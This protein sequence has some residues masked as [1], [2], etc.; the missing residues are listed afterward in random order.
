MSY[1]AI[2]THVQPGA[3]AAPRLACARKLAQRFGAH[4]IGV[5]AE[6]IQTLTFDNGYYALD[7]E[8]TVAMRQTIEQ[9]LDVAHEDFKRETASLGAAG[10]SWSRGIDSP[11]PALAA[12]SRA[13]DIIVAGGAPRGA[14]NAYP[15]ISAA[16]LTIQAGRPVLVAPPTAKDLSAEKVVLA[17]KDTREARRAL[18]D[19]LPFLV[20]ARGVLVLEVTDQDDEE[21]ARIRT[22]DVARALVRRGVAAEARVT[23]HDHAPAAQRLLE[24]AA[25]YG[26]DLI[27]LGCYGHSRPGEW[28]F[29]GVT[30]DH[31]AQDD[32]FLLLSH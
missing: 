4:L 19:A 31:L 32:V 1:S 25:A 29:G 18:S 24:A 6:M 16:E 2:I 9:Q 30:R 12:A 28:V 26:A 13:A 8:W 23:L 15:D 14:E 17:W 27:V 10:T 21:D 22:E 5:G 11:T 3:D 7:A 20:T